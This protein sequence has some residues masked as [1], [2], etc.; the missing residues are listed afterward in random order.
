[1]HILTI[2]IKTSLEI[3]NVI[4]MDKSLLSI[5]LFTLHRKL[6]VRFYYF[7]NEKNEAQCGLRSL[8]KITQGQ[9]CQ[10]LNRGSV[11]TNDHTLKILI[12]F[13]EN[14]LLHFLSHRRKG[15]G[16]GNLIFN[17]D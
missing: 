16:S 3:H 1:M 2:E 8:P 4:V 6:C 9:G 5:I 17:E 14:C 7:T 15:I 10:D 11:I 12:G 13:E